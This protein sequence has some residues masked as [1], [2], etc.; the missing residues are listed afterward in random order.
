M[1]PK[2]LHPA[3]IFLAA[4]SY[5]RRLLV[6]VGLVLFQVGRDQSTSTLLGVFVGVLFI[7]L[8]AAF[9]DWWRFRFSLEGS[10]F[11]IT[12]GVVSLKR[13]EIPLAKIQDLAFER[14]A[15]HRILGLVSVSLQTSGTAGAEAALSAVSE[16][17]A[18]E[19]KRLLVGPGTGVTDGV[20]K[21][22][23]SAPAAPIIRL[24]VRDL[25][26]R[27]LTDNRAGLL[28]A[29][30]LGV[31][32]EALEAQADLVK[33]LIMG[34][35]A[36]FDDAGALGGTTLIAVA[37]IIVWLLGYIASSVFNLLVFYGFELRE[38]DGT[39]HRRFGLITLKSHSLPRGRIQALTIHQ[40][41]MRRL[42]GV[43]SVQVR[44]MGGGQDQQEAKRV[45]SDT[46]VP[47]G[48]LSALLGVRRHVFPDAPTPNWRRVS[49]RLV[50]RSATAG[51]LLTTPFFVL[52]YFNDSAAMAFLPIVG[53]VLGGLAGWR[54]YHVLAYDFSADYFALRD[55]I[56]GRTWT[57]I[58]LR[59]IEAVRIDRSPLDRWHGVATLRVVVGGGGVF[60][61]PNVA[62][63][64]AEHVRDE[65]ERA[66]PVPR[67]REF[68]PSGAQA[69][70][71]PL[72]L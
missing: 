37:L 9:V 66:L 25:I 52:A 16:D 23:P 2:R 70:T 11:V 56:F 35:A 3:H 67:I 38:R 44:D 51:A 15:L 33:V 22:A 8:G 21:D 57:D 17:D 5:L 28:I 53:A 60:S 27:G 19:L 14:N 49:T 41:L 55:G 39:F 47:A 69:P 45:G 43:A 50:R 31:F 30:A 20:T 61:V 48:K 42:L 24:G 40:T 29:G 65:V 36:R 18:E 63:S 1:R 7:I 71:E 34:A 13:R 4:A 62:L 46:F 32:H 10:H 72:P 6:F 59:R 58:P 54:R 68:E 64:S 26:L 12:S